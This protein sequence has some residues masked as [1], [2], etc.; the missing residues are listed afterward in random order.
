MEILKMNVHGGG[1]APPDLDSP[2][3]FLP[4][5]KPELGPRLKIYGYSLTG[6]SWT[7]HHTVGKTYLEA[8]L[9]LD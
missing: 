7:C 1:A 5:P 2:P 9:L 6:G 4:P 8:L 3:I